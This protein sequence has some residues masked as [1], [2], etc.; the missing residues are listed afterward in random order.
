ME[1][2]DLKK[3]WDSPNKE[4]ENFLNINDQSFEL[5]QIK[6]AKSKVKSLIFSKI[7]GITLGLGWISFMFILIYFTV[8]NT[9]I[10]FGKF[11][12]VGSLSIIVLI[13][14]LAV[15]LYVKDIITIKQI[16]N[17]E[18]VT[19]TQLKLASLQLSII[20]SVRVSW[21]QLP[22]YSTWYLNYELIMKGNIIFWIVQI[23]VTGITTWL[24]IWLFRNINYKNLNKKRVRNLMQGVGFYSVTQAMDYIKE[25]DNFKNDR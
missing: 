13:T 7:V 10:S 14:S 20:K 4:I 1:D 3:I 15:F 16:D 12:F 18:S 5:T 11:F 8:F 2:E 21:L 17:S 23:F 25:I 9:P 22:F 19:V 24:A 6:K